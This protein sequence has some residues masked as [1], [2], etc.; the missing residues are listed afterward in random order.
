[1]GIYYILG[2]RMEK[3]DWH[4]IEG[5]NSL[6]SMTL[7]KCCGVV[8]SVNKG[9]NFLTFI[10]N[11]VSSL[12]SDSTGVVEATLFEDELLYQMMELP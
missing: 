3:L 12:V 4:F 8:L 5:L 6:E 11:I 1:M 10:S 9:H 7:V 2:A